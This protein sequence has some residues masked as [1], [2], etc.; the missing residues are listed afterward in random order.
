VDLRVVHARTVI[1]DQGVWSGTNG[2]GHGPDVHTCVAGSQ[3]GM[4][5]A[6]AQSAF[7]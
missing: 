5:M 3:F 7:E 1:E 2:Q 6:S 4:P